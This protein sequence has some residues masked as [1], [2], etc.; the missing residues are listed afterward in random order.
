MK[1]AVLTDLHVGITDAADVRRIRAKVEAESASVVVL[2]GDLGEP[3]PNFEL[4][5]DVFNGYDGDVAVVAGNHDVWW[6]PGIP[7]S[8]E[9]WE[10]YLPRAAR[11]RGFIWLESESLVVDDTAIV[12]TIAWYDYSSRSPA[13]ETKSDKAFFE[14]KGAY[15]NDGN[16][17]DWPWNDVEF[18]RTVGRAFIQRLEKAQQDD[19][20]KR[21][22]AITHVPVFPEQKV[23][24]KKWSTAGDAY[25]GNW[26]LGQQMEAF[27]KV[28]AVVSGH[29]HMGCI[30]RHTC[31][32]GRSLPVVVIGSDYHKPAYLIVDTETLE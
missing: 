23:P 7:S 12:G 22:V 30:T 6:R 29:T 13:F 26:T 1:I 10:T 32:D 14:T 27:S 11:S 3:L 16:F 24:I 15:N 18:A 8:R 28:R 25:Y 4:A 9:L 17:I 19:S 21:I 31:A 2:A 20:I 5:L